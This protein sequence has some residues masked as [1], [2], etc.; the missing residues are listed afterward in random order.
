MQAAT[1]FVGGKKA[2]LGDDPSDPLQ[3]YGAI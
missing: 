2:N 3:S 1:I